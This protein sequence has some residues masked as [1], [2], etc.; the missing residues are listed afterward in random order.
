MPRMSL[1]RA[2]EYIADDID[3][4]GDDILEELRE[5]IADKTF[6]D[7]G[8]LRD[9][10]FAG[11][12]GVYSSDDKDKVLANEYGTIHMTGSGAVR[13]SMRELPQ[14]IREVRKR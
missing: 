5:R 9:S 2:L 11:E 12:D 6:V 14:I 7:T 3:G 13:R 1:E 8:E 10:W 4:L